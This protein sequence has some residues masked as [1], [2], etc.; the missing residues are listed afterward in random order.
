M[1]PWVNLAFGQRRHNTVHV[2][3]ARRIE[4]AAIAMDELAVSAG[5]SPPP[6]NIVG[7]TPEVIA[8]ANTLQLPLVDTKQYFSMETSNE[9]IP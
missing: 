1:K 4:P 3:S 7:D 6:R 5:P 2:E 8:N 9:P